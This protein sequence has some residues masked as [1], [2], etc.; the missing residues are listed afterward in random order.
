MAK[1]PRGLRNNNPGNIKRSAIPWKGKTKGKDP[2]FETFDCI[3]NGV[4]AIYKNLIHYIVKD[5]ADTIREI[6]DKWA[7]PEGNDTEAYIAHVCRISGE[8][9]A[10]MIRPIF[11]DLEPIVR[12][13]CIHENGGDLIPEEVFQMAWHEVQIAR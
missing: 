10:Q 9:D 13:I 8:K 2:T 4:A 1:L 12:A 6:I 11:E 5:R 3:E 7:P